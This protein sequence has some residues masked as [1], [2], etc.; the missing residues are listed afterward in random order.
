MRTSLRLLQEAVA[1]TRAANPSVVRDTFRRSTRMSSADAAGRPEMDTKYVVVEV[2]YTALPTDVHRALR[3]VGAVPKKFPLSAVVH[4]PVGGTRKASL[5]TRYHL[6]APD[7]KS[8]ETMYNVLMSRPL[9]AAGSARASAQPGRPAFGANGLK[10]EAR[11]VYTS[12]DAF[13]WVDG[14]LRMVS[15][16]QKPDW[17]ASQQAAQAQRLGQLP[18]AEWALAPNMSGRRVLLRGLPRERPIELVRD[19]LRE[20]GVEVDREGIKRLVNA[21]LGSRSALV[22]TCKSVADAHYLARRTNKAPYLKGV[23]G[24]EYMMRS[25]VVW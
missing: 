16:N 14:I 22:V 17:Q 20:V 25:H 7:S 6:T 18:D 11:V 10:N 9:F 15:R 4:E 2:P 19:F 12:R 13:G 1:A 3:E 8:G 23:M 21:Q 24:Y 5:M